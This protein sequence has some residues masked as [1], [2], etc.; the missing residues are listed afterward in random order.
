[1]V[2]EK[3]FW[4]T[5]VV[6]ASDGSMYA[7]ISTDPERRVR[8]HNGTRR[9]SKCLRGRRPV[10]LLGVAGPFSQRLAMEYERAFKRLTRVEKE[11]LLG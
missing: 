6:R 8:E 2:K 7:G 1:M 4:F 9:G 5:Y 11:R 3:R 10:T